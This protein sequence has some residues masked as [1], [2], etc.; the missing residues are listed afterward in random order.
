MQFLKR[1]EKI[2]KKYELINITLKTLINDSNKSIH[3]FEMLNNC[4]Y[5]QLNDLKKKCII[6]IIKRSI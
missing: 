5:Y 3:F 1:D 4:G 2:E 6:S